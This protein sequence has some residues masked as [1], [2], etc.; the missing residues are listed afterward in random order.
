MRLTIMISS[1]LSRA[2]YLGSVE[3]KQFRPYRGNIMF[4][5]NCNII[6]ELKIWILNY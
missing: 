5:I 1:F 3:N 6:C 2:I 4:L